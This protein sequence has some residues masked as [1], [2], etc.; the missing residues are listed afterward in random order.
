LGLAGQI[1]VIRRNLFELLA[2]G[3]VVSI[4]S[5]NTVLVVDIIKKQVSDVIVLNC[6]TYNSTDGAIFTKPFYDAS[7]LVYC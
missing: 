4:L 5:N 7:L 2:E 1:G 3:Y 6:D